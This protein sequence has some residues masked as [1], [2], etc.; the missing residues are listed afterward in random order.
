MTPQTHSLPNRPCPAAERRAHVR[1]RAFLARQS[2]ARIGAPDEPPCE[3]QLLD[4]SIYGCRLGIQTSAQHGEKV[5]ILLS[6]AN[7]VEATL[8]W[9]ESGRIGCRFDEPIE[10]SL[11]RSLNLPAA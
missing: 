5:R 2:Q 6:G 4:L 3:A 7:P 11:F 1:H 9:N 8:I 10:R